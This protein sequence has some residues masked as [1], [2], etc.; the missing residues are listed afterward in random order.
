MITRLDP[1]GSATN[2]IVSVD[3]LRKHGF[4]TYL[5]YGPTMDPDGAIES[6]LSSIATP[7]FY[8]PNLV[9]NPSI[10]N[11][12]L[13]FSR[14]KKIIKNGSFDLVHTHTS[15]AGILGRLAARACGVPSIH[16][17]HGH[18]FYGYFGP[19][20]TNLF[21]HAERLMARHTEKIIS[22]TNIETSESLEKG[23]GTPDQYTTIHSGVPLASF[24]DINPASGAA[25]RK[26]M[27]I[28]E[29]AFVFV[30]IGRLVPV[31]GF[32]ILLKAF[33][34]AIF[35]NK[36]TCLIVAGDGDEK[37]RLESMAVDLGIADR[38]KFTGTLQDVRPALSSANVFV[39]AS[40]NEGMGR[41]FVEA[42]AAGLPAI[43]TTV[44]GIPTL[45]DPGNTGWLVPPEN[46][47]AL[48]TALNEASAGVDMLKRMGRT[49]ASFVFPEY[50]EET[51][52]DRLA[53]LY[54]EVLSKTA[55]QHSTVSG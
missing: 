11:D 47:S 53:T 30:S 42:M 50:D 35:T 29:S 21:V 22:L 1:G 6:R 54:R 10:F 2:T 12:S 13:A 3:R 37:S 17:P 18:I 9:R 48:A 19:L 32:D 28:D 49:A 25:L 52:I 5:A 51:M 23:I 15:K 16:T 45:I 34:E 55:K 27:G 26:Q 36:N 40:R 43:G 8:V 39:L 7:R 31:K 38:V 44:G 20:L 33:A 24:R 46:P 41:V 4:D 14:L